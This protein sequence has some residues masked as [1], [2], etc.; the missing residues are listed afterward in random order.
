MS[1]WEPPWSGPVAPNLPDTPWFLQVL[2]PG[3]VIKVMAVLP[4]TTIIPSLKESTVVTAG[5][6][7]GTNGIGASKYS[8]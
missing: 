7:K 5:I 1:Y 6:V 4:P 2:R 8:C 3:V